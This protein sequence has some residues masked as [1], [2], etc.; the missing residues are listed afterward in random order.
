MTNEIYQEPK[1]EI[2]DL[3]LSEGF[4]LTGSGQTEQWQE[5]N[6]PW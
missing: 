2:V 3:G 5:E 6:F 1:V 4:C